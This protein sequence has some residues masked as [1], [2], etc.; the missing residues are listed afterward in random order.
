MKNRIRSKIASKILGKISQKI[1]DTLNVSS[2]KQAIKD[3][4]QAQASVKDSTELWDCSICHKQ[5]MAYEYAKHYFKC[6]SK[7][8]VKGTIPKTEQIAK[9]SIQNE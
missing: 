7:S 5:I 6:Y 9:V 2:A 4:K 8:V 1:D 3:L